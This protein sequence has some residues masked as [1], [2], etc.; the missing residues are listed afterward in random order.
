[1]EGGAEVLQQHG[2]LQRLPL[3]QGYQDNLS[4]DEKVNEYIL[5]YMIKYFLESK[6]QFSH[7]LYILIDLLKYNS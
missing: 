3:R 1:M 6:Y 7:L 4:H 2:H 5:N